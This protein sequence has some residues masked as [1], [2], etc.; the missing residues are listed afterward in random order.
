MLEPVLRKPRMSK[1]VTG[2][3]LTLSSQF[4]SSTFLILSELEPVLRSELEPVLRKARMSKMVTGGCW[5]TGW[6]LRHGRRAAGRLRDPDYNYVD[7][8][9]CH[10]TLT[11]SFCRWVIF[12]F[13]THSLHCLV[14]CAKLFNTTYSFGVCWLCYPLL[15]SDGPTKLPQL[16]MFHK[17]HCQK[18][19]YPGVCAKAITL[20]IFVFLCFYWS[21]LVR[22]RLITVC[23][24]AINVNIKKC[25]YSLWSQDWFHKIAKVVNKQMDDKNVQSAN[26]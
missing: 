10:N 18:L 21:S 26:R 9:S 13:I 14:I 17:N 16:R 7:H 11:G 2:V 8:Q 24:P 12:S 1:M 23:S 20:C 5:L 19:F 25:R 4:S 22:S 6:W 15:R 3:W